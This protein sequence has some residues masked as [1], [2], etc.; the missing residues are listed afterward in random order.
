MELP[1]TESV[2]EVLVLGERV[3]MVISSFRCLLDI[4]VKLH[5]Q[6]AADSESGV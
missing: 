1:L 4:Q 6:Q 5:V 3:M 2:W